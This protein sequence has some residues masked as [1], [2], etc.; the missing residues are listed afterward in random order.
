VLCTYSSSLSL[1]HRVCD[2][3]RANDG[4]ALVRSPQAAVRKGAR[5]RST[6]PPARSL[7]LSAM[8]T[9]VVSPVT[10]DDFPRLAEIQEAASIDGPLRR[11]AF[12][13]VSKEDYTAWFAH[14][15][16]H[17]VA[18]PGLRTELWCA[19]KP[20]TGEIG[21]WARWFMS[22]NDGETSTPAPPAERT[23]APLPR[24]IDT[25]V[26]D[27]GIKEIIS[28]Q[29]RIMGTRKNWSTSARTPLFA[30]RLTFS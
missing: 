1:F 13:A 4:L 16:A 9:F 30:L 29:A 22:A 20:E 21:G 17:S 18:P 6:R 2:H 3:L 5:K 12:A 10:P 24:G 26:W 11:A 7:R 25:H 15:L 14:G 23:P 27:T 28:H 19:R 8:S